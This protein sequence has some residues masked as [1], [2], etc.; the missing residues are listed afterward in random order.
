MDAK[1]SESIEKL[2]SYKDSILEAG[3][4]ARVEKQHSQGK[5]TARERMEALFDDDT[6]VEIDDMVTSSAV[7]FGMDKKKKLT[8]AQALG[9]R[10]SSVS[11]RLKR[12]REKLRDLLE[13]GDDP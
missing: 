11:E 6:F 10:H 1:W 5:L 3:G 9:I 2:V 12:A 13:G 7:D 4:E 8:K